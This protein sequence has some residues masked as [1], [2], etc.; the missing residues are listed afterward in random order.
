[1]TERARTAWVRMYCS[2]D[3][4]ARVATFRQAGT[5]WQLASVGGPA[6]AGTGAGGSPV[7][8]TFGYAPGYRGC[9]CGSN[10]YVRCSGCGELGCWQHG[11]SYFTCGNCGV[12]GYPSGSLDSLGAID[13][14]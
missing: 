7:S 9:P 12:G 10:S 6:P 11:A 13:A 2:Q 3:R 8:G 1:M 5:E 14:S 4:Q